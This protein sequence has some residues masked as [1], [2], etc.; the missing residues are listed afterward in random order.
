MDLNEKITRKNEKIT[1]KDY[2]KSL[3][4]K[5]KIRIR[6]KILFNCEMS[7]SSFYSKQIKENGFS[8][9]ERGEINRICKTLFEW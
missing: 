5:E 8:R 7:Y 6:D 9:L 3:D 4:E 2:Y 1:F